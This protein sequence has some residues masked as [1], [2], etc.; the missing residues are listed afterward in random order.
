MSWYSSSKYGWSWG[1]CLLNDN[2]EC[3]V[4][5]DCLHVS[6]EMLEIMFRVKNYDKFM[7]ISDS[8]PTSGAPE[9]KYSFGSFGA[10]NVTPEGFC[11]TETGGL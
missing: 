3:E 6:A 10:V 8:T 1:A 5:C 4:I 9:G 7:M 2:V 11:L